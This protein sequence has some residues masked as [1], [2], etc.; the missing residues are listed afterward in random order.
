MK[1]FMFLFLI[2]AFVAVMAGGAMAK[3]DCT[4][5]GPT[6]DTLSVNMQVLPCNVMRITET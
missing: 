6:S 2:V 1:K 5:G 4:C 3:E